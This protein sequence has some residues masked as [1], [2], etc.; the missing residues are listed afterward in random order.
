MRTRALV[1]DLENMVE[2][3][4]GRAERSQ[5]AR[6]LFFVGISF[7]QDMQMDCKPDCRV[8]SFQWKA[9]NIVISAPVDFLKSPADH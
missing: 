6:S 3:D 8:D 4:R 2:E 1:R 9:P 7:S 5:S